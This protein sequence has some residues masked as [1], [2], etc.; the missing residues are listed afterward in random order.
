MIK[1]QRGREK[2]SGQCERLKLRCER[3]TR[4]KGNWKAEGRGS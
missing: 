2:M 1:S 4:N 3:T